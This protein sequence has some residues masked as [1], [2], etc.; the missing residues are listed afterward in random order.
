M[1]SVLSFFILLS[2]VYACGLKYTPVETRVS[3]EKNR[4][5]E[6]DQY[7][8]KS[9]EDSSVVYR[10]LL[11]SPA[12]LVKPYQY[13]RLDS[14]YEVKY[15]NE[16]TGVFDAEL[17]NQIKNQKLVIANSNQKIKYIEHPVYS[18][19]KGDTSHVYFSDITYQDSILDFQINQIYRIPNNQTSILISYL[20]NESLIYPTY[21]ATEQEKELYTNFK[22]ALNN[23]PIYEQNAF[24]NHALNVFSIVRNK[25]TVATKEIIQNIVLLKL[26]NRYYNDQLDYFDSVNGVWDGETLLSYEVKMNCPKGRY[27]LTLNLFFELTSVQ[28]LTE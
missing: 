9:Y 15:N 12:T 14:L 1:K 18:I 8:Q 6:I 23:R 10:N 22:D 4:R 21:Q 28:K 20:T 16:Q 7:I 11:Y 24:L 17:E 13:R 5:T 19:I 2:L 3:L 26:E 27:F 25:R